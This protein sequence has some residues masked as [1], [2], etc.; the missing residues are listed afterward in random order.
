MHASYRYLAEHSAPLGIIKQGEVCALTGFQLWQVTVQVRDF[1]F[2]FGKTP[3]S[4][5]ARRFIDTEL[6]LRWPCAA[7]SCFFSIIFS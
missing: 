7:L 1:L 2:L 4:G 3:D 5:T 6:V